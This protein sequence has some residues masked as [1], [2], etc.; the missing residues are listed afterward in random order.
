[1]KLYPVSHS[2]INIQYSRV[3]NY[4]IAKPAIQDNTKSNFGLYSPDKKLLVSF[5]G[6]A[7]ETMD[8]KP[9]IDMLKNIDSS[10]ERPPFDDSEIEEISQTLNKVNAPYLEVILNSG[11]N[12]KYI[13]MILGEVNETNAPFLEPILKAKGK[14]DRRRFNEFIAKNILSKINEL[15]APFVNV[16]LEQYD[17]GR[18]RFNSYFGEIIGNI[19]EDNVRIVNTLLYTPNRDNTK[20]FEGKS[21]YGILSKTNRGNVKCVKPLVNKKDNNEEYKFTGEEIRDIL[22]VVNEGNAQCVNFLIDAQKINGESRYTSEEIVAILSNTNEDNA[23]CVE[24][25][26]EEEDNNNNRRFFAHQIADILSVTNSFNK[27]LLADLLK[28]QDEDSQPQYTSEEIIQTLK[29]S[30]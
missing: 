26:T 20:R 18:V 13:A 29:D 25:L 17:N 30:I 16:L 23:D 22:E 11:A 12:N 10:N 28:A 14:E 9:Y 15:N 1:M 3:K 24:I 7:E 2:P 4:S 5:S 6:E 21:I 27:E 19:T 8:K